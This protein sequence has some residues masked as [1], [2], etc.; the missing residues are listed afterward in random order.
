VERT[1]VNGNGNKGGRPPIYNETIPERAYRLCLLGLIDTELAIAFDV[2]VSTI[3]NWKKV[4]PEFSKSLKKGK[5]DADAKVAVSLFQR[6]NGY[7]HPSEHI[8]T[9]K[10]VNDGTE[11]IEI[12]KT[13]IMKY[14]APDTTACIFWLKNRQKELW[15]DVN[16]S[17]ITGA[18]GAPLVLEHKV[19]LSEFSD[20][21]LK[22][23]VKLGFKKKSLLGKKKEED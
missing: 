23:A 1:K 17:E 14:Y 15:R 19:D 21:E 18:D 16:R 13:P 6:A 7:S 5:K 2:D 12:I 8:T 20:D 22:L 3:D 11:E 4:H 9:R 10:V